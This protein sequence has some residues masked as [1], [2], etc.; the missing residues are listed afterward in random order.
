[1]EKIGMNKI[2]DKKEGHNNRYQGHPE[3]HKDTLKKKKNKL[4]LH[5]IGKS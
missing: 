3:N 4:V 1:M 2:R 5:Q